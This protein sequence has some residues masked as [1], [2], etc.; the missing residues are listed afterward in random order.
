MDFPYSDTVAWIGVGFKNNREWIYIGFSVSPNL[1]DTRTE[2]WYNVIKTKIKIND[3]INDVT[4]TQDWGD[5]FLSFLYGEQTIKDIESGDKLLITLNWHGNGTVYFNF[6]L[7]GSSKA[8]KI[9][10]KECK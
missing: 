8:L 7:K 4:L 10:R 2:D 9:M 6:D 1:N 3:K 5:K